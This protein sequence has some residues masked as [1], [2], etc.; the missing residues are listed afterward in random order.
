MV[1]DTV[2]TASAAQ[3]ADRLPPLSETALR[4][5]PFLAGDHWH[6]G[7]GWIG[8]LPHDPAARALALRDIAAAF[9]WQ[10]VLGRARDRHRDG[11]VGR[12]PRWDLFQATTP[13]GA[14]LTSWWD[15]RR[16]GLLLQTTVDLLLRDTRCVWRL[17]L[18][19]LPTGTSQDALCHAIAI[20]VLP[21]SQAT[22]LDDAWSQPAVGIAHVHDGTDA[23]LELTAQRDT[24]TVLRLLRGDTVVDEAS[25]QLGGRLLHYELRREAFFSPACLQLQQALNLAY[26]QMVRNVNLA[27]SRE[28]W[29]LNAQPPGYWSAAQP[30]ERGA[31]QVSPGI[32]QRYVVTPAALGPGG[33]TYL[34]GA[35]VRDNDDRL[36]GY[37]NPSINFVEPIATTTFE[38][39]IATLKRALHE[40]TNQLHVLMGDD[41]TAS[42][43]SR[44]EA[45]AEFITSL[46]ATATPLESAIRWLLE[47]VSVW[48]H[49]LAGLSIPD[50]RA[51]AACRLSA[52][53]L[54]PTDMLAISQLVNA[55]HLSLETA[56]TMFGID[57]P[58]AELLRLRVTAPVSVIT[59]ELSTH[60]TTEL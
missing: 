28:R 49:D 54:A 23:L 30:D 5:A 11:V 31:I 9:I 43:R 34:Q 59:S 8:A 55:G 50:V 32:W 4:L 56:L 10:D 26:T 60:D 24:M 19:D 44:L 12:E 38:A 13:V 33:V 1:T 29:A 37:A 3:L 25:Y 58:D 39:T 6:S 17:M 21:A 14:A 7:G 52:G 47:T 42:G 45:R 20:Q 48:S 15:A 40:E 57:D 18:P 46:R 53:P 16:M 36:M 27:G 2:F 22:V 41:A 51:E 35:E